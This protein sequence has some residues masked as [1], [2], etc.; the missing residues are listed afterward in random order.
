MED[1]LRDILKDS[2]AVEFF[3]TGSRKDSRVIPHINSRTR[4]LV[5]VCDLDRFTIGVVS[6]TFDL[7]QF[8]ELVRSYQ[9]GELKI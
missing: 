3:E 8:E 5:L 6:E 9:L 7:E 4:L 2:K 1:F